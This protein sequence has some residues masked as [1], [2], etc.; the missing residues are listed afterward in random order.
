MAI[1]I[2]NSEVELL[3]RELS[4]WTGAGMT[5]EILQALRERRERL[6]AGREETLRRIERIA[7]ACAALP[8]IDPRSPDAILGYGETG[9]F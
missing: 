3:A 8:V 4:S 7:E 6:T 2:R 9:A 5:E 1:S